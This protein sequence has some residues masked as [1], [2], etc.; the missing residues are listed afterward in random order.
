MPPDLRTAACCP[1]RRPLSGLCRQAGY[2]Q[3]LYGVYLSL[4]RSLPDWW[5]AAGGLCGMIGIPLECIGYYGICRLFADT[6]P[7]LAKPYR[8]SIWSFCALGALIHILCAVSMYFYKVVEASRADAYMEV[9]RFLMLFMALPTA[10]FCGGVSV[11]GRHAVSCVLER[12]NAL[13][14]MDGVCKPPD[15]EAFVQRYRLSAPQHRRSKRYSDFQYQPEQH[16]AI[17]S[18]DSASPKKAQPEPRATD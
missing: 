12:E 6:T 14:Q 7:K 8:V 17:P 18:A 2:I 10:L 4:A 5:L 9:L 1:R 16:T 3:Y 13:P 11:D 15:G